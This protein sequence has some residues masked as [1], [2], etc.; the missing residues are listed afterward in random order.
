MPVTVILSDGVMVKRLTVTLDEDLHTM[1]E[2]IAAEEE[3]T[4]ANL[5]A[6]LGRER[7]KAWRQEQNAPQAEGKT[8]EKSICISLPSRRHSS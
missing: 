1:L 3:R 4:V 6:F 5:L 7:V 8:H 2:K